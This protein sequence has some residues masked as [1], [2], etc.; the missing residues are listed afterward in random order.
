MR[1]NRI[2]G[3]KRDAE[4]WLDRFAYKESAHHL[5]LMAFLQRLVNSDGEIIREMAV[6]NGR[7]DMLIKFHGQRVAMEL[8]INRGKKYIEKAK[9]QLSRYLDGLGL[10]QGYLVIFDQVLGK[11]SFLI[12][13]LTL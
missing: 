8:K 5:L 13:I 3:I 11:I 7:V 1:K 4:V 10:K 12:I 2:G 6:G 9:K